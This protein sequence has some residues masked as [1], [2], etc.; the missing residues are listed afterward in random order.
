METLLNTD[1]FVQI[2]TENNTNIQNTYTDFI[3]K[4]LSF[5]RSGGDTISVYFVLNYTRVEF[6]II[7]NRI[8]EYKSEKKRS[9]G[10]PI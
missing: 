9:A 1:F 4:I 7:L 2:K 3:K 5:C 10:L 6:L 8:T